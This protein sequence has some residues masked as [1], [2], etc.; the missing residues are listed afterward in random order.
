M[1]PGQ[2]EYDLDVFYRRLACVVVAMLAT[3]TG[4]ACGSVAQNGWRDSGPWHWGALHL[5]VPLITYL[6]VVAA[7]VRIAWRR[8]ATVGNGVLA[9]GTI[10]ILCC[11]L[12]FTFLTEPFHLPSKLRVCCAA[13]LIVEILITTWFARRYLRGKGNAVGYGILAMFVTFLAGAI[14]FSTIVSTELARSPAPVL[15]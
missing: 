12:P 3:L 5:I 2:N 13:L 6:L 8:G 10:C 14:A 7:S 15:D 11:L 1:P 4:Y 9:L